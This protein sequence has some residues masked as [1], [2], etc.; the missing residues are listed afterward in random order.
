[1]VM[2][3]FEQDEMYF[4]RQLTFFLVVLQ[5]NRPER[6]TYLHFLSGLQTLDLFGQHFPVGINKTHLAVLGHFALEIVVQ[7]V[8][9]LHDLYILGTNQHAHFCARQVLVVVLN[10]KLIS[11][12]RQYTH[13]VVY[14]LENTGLHFAIPF[15]EFP[16]RYSVLFIQIRLRSRVRTI[17]LCT[18]YIVPL[19]FPEVNILRPNHYIH[20][21]V[22]AKTGVDAIEHLS[23]E[24]HFLVFDHRA[25][26]DVALTDKISYKAVLRLVVNICRSTDLLDLSFA[27]HHHTVAQRQRLFLVVGDVNKGDSQL[28][29]QLFQLDLHIVAHLQIQS[30]QGFI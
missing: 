21:I 5:V 14:T 26:Q 13:L 9:F 15:R 7:I 23:A 11:V 22:L 29:M 28:F 18:L 4:T 17:V 6:H 27:H 20:R 19:Y 30:A 8:L 24:L 10:Q 12:R 1:M 25:A 3:A 16:F 2:V